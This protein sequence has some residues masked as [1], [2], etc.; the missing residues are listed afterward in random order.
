MERVATGIVGAVLE[1]SDC[2][3][4]FFVLVGDSSSRFAGS[5]E[6]VRVGTL[7]IKLLRLVPERKKANIRVQE[8]ATAT[9]Y[10]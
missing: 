5:C 2:F 3:S 6:Y 10:C 8:A 1:Q 4:F 9:R 7:L